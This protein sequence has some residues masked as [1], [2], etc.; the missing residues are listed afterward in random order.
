VEL[1]TGKESPIVNICMIINGWEADNFAVQ[2]NDKVLQEKKDFW[3]GL[4]SGLDREDVII[5]IEYESFSNSRI[6]INRK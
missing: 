1:I 3:I 5:W 2:M 6:L 4:R